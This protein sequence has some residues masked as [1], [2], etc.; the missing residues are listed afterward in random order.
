MSSSLSRL[1]GILLLELDVL[2]R[3]W[4]LVWKEVKTTSESRGITQDQR[5]M[6]YE[7]RRTERWDIWRPN[8]QTT[9]CYS[10]QNCSICQ[11]NKQSL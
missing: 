5:A 7:G 8:T 1:G 11:K 10:A 6:R 3:R 9:V 2:L 4:R